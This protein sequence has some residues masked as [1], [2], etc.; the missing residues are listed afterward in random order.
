[1]HVYEMTKTMR[2]TVPP[3]G[4]REEDKEVSH[5]VYCRTGKRLMVGN[6]TD[7]QDRKT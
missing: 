7:E 2:S 1:M 3:L 5:V 6:V 4:G